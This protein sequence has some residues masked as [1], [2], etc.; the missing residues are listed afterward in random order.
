MHAFTA[1]CPPW[2]DERDD[3]RHAPGDDH[4]CD[5]LAAAL[6]L[7]PGEPLYV[8]AL[9][10]DD[11][12][13]APARVELQHGETSAGTLRLPPGEARRVAAALLAAADL[14]EQPGPRSP[15]PARRGPRTP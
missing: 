11:D 2:C 14:A 9:V 7:H 4:T 1:P 10:P 12:P 13:Y 5:T 6:A 15:R 8:Y 3:P